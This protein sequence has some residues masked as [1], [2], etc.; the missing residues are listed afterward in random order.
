MHTHALVP[1]TAPGC[2]PALPVPRAAP[3]DTGTPFSMPNPSAGMWFGAGQTLTQKQPQF[4]SPVAVESFQ[5]GQDALAA[6]R[7]PG[8]GVCARLLL[9]QESKGGT[10]S[11]ALKPQQLLLRRCLSSA[12]LSP[13]MSPVPP[14]ALLKGRATA[15]LSPLFS[16]HLG[17]AKVRPAFGLVLGKQNWVSSK[18]VSHLCHEP[19][20]Q[21][22]WPWL[23]PTARRR[24]ISVGH[25]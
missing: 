2:P 5:A 16:F 18:K 24:S 7:G 8:S 17:T 20:S 3:A 23:V 14:T 4:I 6:S 21:K 11:T 9:Q 25:V 22:G 12:I 10:G 19:A 15:K 13:P 1:S